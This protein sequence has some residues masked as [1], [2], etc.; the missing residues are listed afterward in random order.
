MAAKYG[1]EA[2]WGLS[3][4][5]TLPLPLS[6]PFLISYP[7]LSIPLTCS[8]YVWSPQRCHFTES[9]MCQTHAA[10]LVAEYLYMLEGLPYIPIGCVAFQTISPNTLEES[11]ISDDVI[12]PVSVCVA[13][14]CHCQIQCASLYLSFSL[15]LSLLSPLSSLVCFATLAVLHTRKRKAYVQVL[16]S[17]F[18]GL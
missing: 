14:I 7:S 13:L 18:L 9:A 6:F 12:N 4:T 2:Q 5:Q 8:P 1:Q 10:A 15:S 16:Y 11:A 3:I 17:M